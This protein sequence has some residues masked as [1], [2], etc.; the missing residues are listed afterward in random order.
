M[1]DPVPPLPSDQAAAL[2]AAA[3]NIATLNDLLPENHVTRADVTTSHYITQ[4]YIVRLRHAGDR[5]GLSNIA[6]MWIGAAIGAAAGGLASGYDFYLKPLHEM[7]LSDAINVI[8]FVCSIMIALSLYLS[9]KRTETVDSICT[10][11]EQR[12]KAKAKS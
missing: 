6:Q 12:K 4:D 9:A 8:V 2:E 3:S 7:R 1:D 11:I 5:A 10:E